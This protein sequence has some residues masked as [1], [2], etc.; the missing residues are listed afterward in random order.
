MSVRK[1][2]GIM[3]VVLL[4]GCGG[5]AQFQTSAS[6]VATNDQ[7]F[8]GYQ[9]TVYPLVKKETCVK[10]HATTSPMFAHSNPARAHEAALDAGKVNFAR[11]ELSRLY[12]RLKNDKHN[13]WYQGDCDRSADEMLQAIYGWR[14]YVKNYS[15]NMGVVTE[16]IPFMPGGKPN[17]PAG[18]YIFEAESGKMVNLGID[19]EGN[20]LEIQEDRA[21]SEGRYVAVPE[22]SRTTSVDDVGRLSNY[23]EFSFTA[24]EAAYRVF[25]RM[26][27]PGGNNNNRLQFQL[28][29]NAGAEFSL[30][31]GSQDNLWH[32]VR[33]PAM[34]ARYSNDGNAANDSNVLKIGVLDDGPKI[35]MIVVFPSSAVPSNLQGTTLA[36]VAEDRVHRLIGRTRTLEYDLSGILAKSAE[37]MGVNSQGVKL[38]LD[39]YVYDEAGY[40][41]D[42]ARIVGHPANVAVFGVRVTLNG[43]FNPQDSDWVRTSRILIPEAVDNAKPVNERD[44]NHDKVALKPMLVQRHLGPSVD[45]IAFAFERLEFTEEEPTVSDIT[46]SASDEENMKSLFRSL[47]INCHSNHDFEDQTRFVIKNDYGK[48]QGQETIDFLSKESGTSYSGVDYPVARVRDTI[49]RVVRPRV[50]DDRGT[51]DTSDDII[52]AGSGPYGSPLY[53]IWSRI[54]PVPAPMQP[55]VDALHNDPINGPK[56]LQSI[57]R[58]MESIPAIDK[59]LDTQGPLLTDVRGISSNPNATT[60]NVNFDAVDDLT[61]IKHISLEVLRRKNTEAAVEHDN[62]LVLPSR[63]STSATLDQDPEV[64]AHYFDAMRGFAGTYNFSRN[65]SFPLTNTNYRFIARAY[66][67]V[68]NPSTS[69]RRDTDTLSPA[70]SHMFTTVGNCDIAITKPAGGFVV[71]GNTTYG[72]TAHGQNSFATGGTT[73]L[74]V[75][76]GNT[77]LRSVSASDSA[78]SNL[79]TGDVNWDP[80]TSAQTTLR[81]TAW[82]GPANQRG[83]GDPRDPYSCTKTLN[84]DTNAAMTGSGQVGAS[85]TMTITLTSDFAVNI[86]SVSVT[87][88]EINQAPVSVSGVSISGKQATFSWVANS[89]DPVTFRATVVD[90]AGTTIQANATITPA[91]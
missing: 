13:C 80:S 31:A 30:A 21:A 64:S 43:Q 29:D 53:R 52:L 49:E 91:P 17:L 47:C 34:T 50:V 28:N 73:R 20:R 46:F 36:T 48:L 45:T 58:W 77:A 67:M 42:N 25:A 57:R 1:F 27:S 23:L 22:K 37:G 81:V 74:L 66:D 33:L 41:I 9:K 65:A 76:V 51:A 32:W 35:D 38:R 90:T 88:Q 26:A 12:L 62:T 4:T 87:K 8:L 6:I 39:M 82:N 2:L 79:L 11:P 59:S 5:E 78:A 10:C 69:P 72:I 7:S 86:G 84:F 70:L 89:R 16:S 55:H 24:S 14:E 54:D 44:P 18:A 68:D 71:T 15:M 56:F 3:A 19:G 60:F 83:D 61:A 63:R 75:E 40:K 85:R